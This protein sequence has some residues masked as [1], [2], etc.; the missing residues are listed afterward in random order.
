MFSLLWEIVLILYAIVLRVVAWSAP[1]KLKPGAPNNIEECGACSLD[2]A[3]YH[4]GY[5]PYR[6]ERGDYI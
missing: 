4:C 5:C 3:S 1:R 2:F 6:E